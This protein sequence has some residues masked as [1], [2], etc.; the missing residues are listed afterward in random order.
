MQTFGSLINKNVVKPIYIYLCRVNQLVLGVS[1][2]F[3]Q[4]QPILR[5]DNIKHINHVFQML[6]KCQAVFKFLHHDS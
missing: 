1:H 4:S 5:K 3:K 2:Y 6:A